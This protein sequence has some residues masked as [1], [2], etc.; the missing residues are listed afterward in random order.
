MGVVAGCPNQ[1]VSS[2][3]DGRGVGLISFVPSHNG[4]HHQHTYDSRETSYDVVVDM[5]IE[6]IL[7]FQQ[8]NIAT[9]SVEDYII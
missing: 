2:F 8:V 6:M 4:H 3:L 5:K 1:V 7:E 9:K